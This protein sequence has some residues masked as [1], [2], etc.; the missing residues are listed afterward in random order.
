MS[1]LLDRLNAQQAHGK[2]AD[3]KHRLFLVDRDLRN[4]LQEAAGYSNPDLTPEGLGKRRRQMEEIARTKAAKQLESL[5]AEQRQAAAQIRAWADGKRPMVADDDAA[6]LNRL[7]M[8]WANVQRALD[9]GRSMAEVITQFSDVPSLMAIREFGP[10]YLWAT[11]PRRS[12]MEGY[13]QQE[14]DTSGLV[15]SVED[16]LAEVAGGDT[17]AAHR[18]RRELEAVEAGWSVSARTLEQTVAGV[19]QDPTALMAAAFE[20]R[21]A[22]QEATAG[23]QDASVAGDGGQQGDAA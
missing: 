1:D 3:L 18:M 13:G 7:T 8:A 4:A 19:R 6:Q 17:A 22:E 14:P 15:R 10:N 20:A 5:Q 11:Q 12:G 16:R 9:N 21:F 23:Y 2:L